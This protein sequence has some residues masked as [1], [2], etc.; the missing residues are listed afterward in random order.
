MLNGLF[1]RS[2]GEA[3]IEQREMGWDAFGPSGAFGSQSTWGGE[4]V[5]HESAASLLAVHGSV[6]LI[7]EQISTLPIEVF[8]EYQ[9]GP[10]TGEIQ[11]V[12]LPRWLEEPTT[13]LDSIE[14]RSQLLMS[15]LYRGNAFLAVTRGSRSQ[16]LEAIPLEP[17]NI[18]VNEQRSQHRITYEVGGKPRPDLEVAHVRGMMQPGHLLGLDPIMNAKQS[19]G[20]GLSALKYGAEFFTNEGN[21]PGVIELSKPVQPEVMRQTARGWRDRR[22]EGGRGMPGILPDGGQWKPT[23]I[24]H[25]QAEFLATRKWTAS[26]IAGQIFLVDP[27]DLGIPVEGASL[28]YGNLEQRN[29][30]RVQ[31]TLLPWIIRLERLITSLLP[32]GQFAKLNVDGLLRGDVKTRWETYELAEKINTS[33]AAR[34]DVP[35]LS[36]QEMRDHEDYGPAPE[37]PTPPE[38]PAPAEPAA[39]EQ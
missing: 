2:A 19:I 14:W 18:S 32:R 24:N 29:A 10:R 25:E 36:T 39:T 23:G 28:T 20:L 3:P 35:V 12:T 33:A 31:V 5:T 16:I 30:R 4:H 15:L 34:G 13:V 1:T 6:R 26:E 11:K 38:P 8:R 27:S 21:M 17:G 22:R 9:E 37:A 7:A